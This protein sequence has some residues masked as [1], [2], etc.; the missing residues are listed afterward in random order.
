MKNKN[1]IRIHTS[2][3]ILNCAVVCLASKGDESY[4]RDTIKL[5]RVGGF[6]RVDHD[7]VVEGIQDQ[8]SRHC[9]CE[10]DCCGHISSGVYDVRYKRGAFLFRV[11]NSRNI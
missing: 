5:T 4:W 8:F 6:R 11:S 2:D 10:H 1:Q 9:S 3:E 7:E